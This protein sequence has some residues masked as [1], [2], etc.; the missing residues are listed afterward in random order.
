MHDVRLANGDLRVLGPGHL[1]EVVRLLERDPVVNVVIDYRARLTRLHP[2]ALGG[3]MWGYYDDDVL[4]S[5][6]HSGANLIPAMATP[7]AAEAFA[8]RARELP[9]T[10]YTLLGP[11]Q[12]VDSMWDRL[13]QAWPAPRDVRRGQRHLEISQAPAVAPDPLVRRSRPEE[14]DALFPACVAMYTEEVGVSPLGNDGGARYR[15]RVTQL[16]SRGWSFVRIEEGKVV[17][18]AEVAATTP[19]ACQLQDVYVAPDRR[20]EGLGTAG[21]AAVVEMV[22]AEVAPVVSLYVNDHNLSARRVYHKIGFRQTAKFT[23][24]LF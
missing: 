10:C 13:R 19:H 9:R 17:F 7:V 2:D 3:E 1:D 6:C 24:I 15:T 20:G 12:A 4:T 22:L 18:K 16:I 14:I 8:D 11:H 23:S 5:V 21:L